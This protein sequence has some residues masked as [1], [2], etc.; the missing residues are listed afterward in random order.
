LKLIYQVEYEAAA[1][2][3]IRTGG[4]MVVFNDVTIVRQGSPDHAALKAQ[5]RIAAKILAVEPVRFVV[6]MNPDP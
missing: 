3:L 2:E 1:K 4:S 6:F 5:G